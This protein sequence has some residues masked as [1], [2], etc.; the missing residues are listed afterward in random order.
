MS[1]QTILVIGGTGLLGGPVA[2]QLSCDGYAVRLLVRD[3][4]RAR[5]RLG[6]QFEY[7]AGDVEDEQSVRQALI[8]CKGVHISLQGRSYR[9]FESVEHRGTARI[10]T[11]ASQ[12]GVE[13]ISYVSGASVCEA[14]RYVPQQRAKYL[15]E[16]A[17]ENSKVPYTIFKPS[18]FMESLPGYIQGKR[19]TVIGQSSTCFHLLAANDFARLVS[20]SFRTPLAANQRFF[21][22]GP[23]AMTLAD[24][25]R[26]Y[27]RLLEPDKEVTVTPYWAMTLI[28]ALF[29][30]RKLRPVIQL[31]KVT[32]RLGETGDAASTAR[33]LGQPATTLQQWCEQQLANRRK[34]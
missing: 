22:Y 1:E 32:A 23:E 24:A 31:M 18:F 5:T 20:A 6:K 15:A 8:G 14:A 11:I 29:M 28:D 9:E 10:A 4:A 27:C 7:I 26:T 17:I 2:R 16:Q 13:R 21:V 30:G 3:P 19:A 33:I 12:I 25:L 34:G